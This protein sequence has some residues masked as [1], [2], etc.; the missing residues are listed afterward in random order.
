VAL[1][2]NLG[3]LPGQVINFLEDAV[4]GTALYSA[5]LASQPMHAPFQGAAAASLAS[6]ASHVELTGVAAPVDHAVMWH[7]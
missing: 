2:N 1:A 6:A 7:G 4:Q 5:S 3:S